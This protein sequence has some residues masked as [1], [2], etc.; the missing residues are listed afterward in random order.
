[1][2]YGLLA[3]AVSE[4]SRLFSLN[5]YVSSEGEFLTTEFT[6]S[7]PFRF[8]RMVLA[9]LGSDSLSIALLAAFSF[10]YMV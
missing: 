2:A 8:F 1:M 3:A 6:I 10:F 7:T 5:L 9:S 4:A